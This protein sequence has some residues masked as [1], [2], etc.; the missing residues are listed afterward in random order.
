MDKAEA[1]VTNMTDTKMRQEEE[2][3]DENQS[4]EH[5]RAHLQ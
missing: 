5:T 1:K 3:D 2:D 4:S